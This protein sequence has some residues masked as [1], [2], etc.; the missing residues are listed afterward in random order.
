MGILK[1]LPIIFDTFYLVNKLSKYFEHI[2][3]NKKDLIAERVEYYNTKFSLGLNV[4]GRKKL[5]NMIKHCIKENVVDSRF[6]K[7]FNNGSMY[8]VF[9]SNWQ[10]IDITAR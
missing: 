3:T 6:Q 2:E 8:F 5:T 10:Y 7:Q 9:Y 1:Q 4:I